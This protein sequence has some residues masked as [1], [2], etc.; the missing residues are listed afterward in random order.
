MLV[1]GQRDRSLPRAFREWF[2]VLGIAMKRMHTL[3]LMP[4]TLNAIKCG[5]YHK[6][7]VWLSLARS[8]RAVRA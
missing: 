7:S 1:G 3:Q 4:N 5:D 6:I 2:A 8:K